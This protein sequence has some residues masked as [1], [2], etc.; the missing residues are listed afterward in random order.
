MI[1]P[2]LPAAL[3]FVKVSSCL[4]SSALRSKNELALIPDAF[5]L[6]LGGMQGT[7]AEGVNQ[8]APRRIQ[9]PVMSK[10]IERVYDL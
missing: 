1:E 2:V 7:A 10:F 3:F 5:A 9:P 4:E 6:S 8:Q